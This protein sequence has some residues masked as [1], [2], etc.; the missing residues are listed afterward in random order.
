MV[1]CQVVINDASITNYNLNLFGRKKVRLVKIDY[2][3]SA[4]GS[5]KLVVIQSDQLRLPYSNYPFLVFSA[6]TNHQVSNIHSDIVFYDVVLD[7]SLSLRVLDYETGVAP[8]NLQFL[9]LL[10]DIYDYDS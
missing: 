3:Y 8:S 1:L 2:R 4:G 5:D 10:F 9:V 7:G 6:N